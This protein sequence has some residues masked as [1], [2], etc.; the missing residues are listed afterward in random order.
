MQ[1]MKGHFILSHQ[2]IIGSGFAA[3]CS[4]EDVSPRK[5]VRRARSGMQLQLARREA[6]AEIGKAPCSN[7]NAI[8]STKD[9]ADCSTCVDRHT[10]IVRT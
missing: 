10:Y 1:Q 2:I 3:S 5:G 4:G 8:Y 6:R 9:C 7:S